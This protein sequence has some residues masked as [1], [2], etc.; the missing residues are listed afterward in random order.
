M[1]CKS[2]VFL[3]SALFC[4][5]TIH[6][7]EAIPTPL[8]KLFPEEELDGALFEEG[9]EEVALNEL[10]REFFADFDHEEIVD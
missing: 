10:E 1:F 5:S 7:E 8:K 3:S 4:F 6:A 9:D 2:I